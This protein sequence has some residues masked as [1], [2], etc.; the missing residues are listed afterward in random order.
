M[1][2]IWF[3]FKSFFVKSVTAIGLSSVSVST[4]IAAPDRSKLP[5]V[6]TNTAS[7]NN[8]IDVVWE[9]IGK[10]IFIAGLAISAVALIVVGNVL[11]GEFNDLRT[12]KGSLG[13][14]GIYALVGILL[15]VAI[16]FFVGKAMDM[17]A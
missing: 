7:S 1:K 3:K 10:G 13:K 16:V 17:F 11:L 8:F 2:R 6:Y 9:I 5:T 15:I 4:A 12:G 14:L